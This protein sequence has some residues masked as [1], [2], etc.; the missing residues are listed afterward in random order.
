MEEAKVMAECSSFHFTLIEG[1][2]SLDFHVMDGLVQG[3]NGPDS[4]TYNVVILIL[5]EKLNQS[6]KV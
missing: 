1:P 4:F 2:D 5:V 6:L 3:S